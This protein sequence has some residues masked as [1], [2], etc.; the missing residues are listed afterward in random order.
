MQD[1]FGEIWNSRDMGVTLQKVIGQWKPGCHLD[2]CMVAFGV[3]DVSHSSVTF[4]AHRV[5][6]FHDCRRVSSIHGALSG[7]RCLSL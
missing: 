4:K 5:A 7:N 3:R 1:S 6:E 2:A